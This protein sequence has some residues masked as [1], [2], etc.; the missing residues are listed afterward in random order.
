LTVSSIGANDEE[1][2]QRRPLNRDEPDGNW[3]QEMRPRHKSSCAS[4]P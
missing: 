3:K 2:E 1:E 4:K